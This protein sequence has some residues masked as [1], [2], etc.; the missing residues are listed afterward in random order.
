MT[1]QPGPGTGPGADASV[2]RFPGAARASS[3]ST[4]SP[5]LDPAAGPASGTESAWTEPTEPEF[6]AAT[7]V[8]TEPPV[9][10]A[11]TASLE[12][13]VTRVGSPRFWVLAPSQ[14][15]R[16]AHC[17]PSGQT[18]AVGAAA[19]AREPPATEPASAT[20]AGE[21]SSARNVRLTHPG[22]APTRAPSRGRRQESNQPLSLT[23]SSRNRSAG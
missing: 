12:S 6:V 10:P 1:E 3:G 13:T 23:L 21:E 15:G 20:S 4:A 16:P 17:P 8:S 14:T 11:R 19:V 22:P 5:V 18:A 2:R 7:K 9:R